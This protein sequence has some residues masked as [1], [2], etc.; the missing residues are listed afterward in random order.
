MTKFIFAC[1]IL[2]ACITA[3]SANPVDT[4]ETVTTGASL[5]REP[6]A[7]VAAWAASETNAMDLIR[8][9]AA[10]KKSHRSAAT[11]TL[12]GG[13]AAMIG[14]VAVSVAVGPCDQNQNGV[15]CSNPVGFVM[16]LGG[17]AATTTGGVMLF[18]E[19]SELKTLRTTYF[20][21]IMN[22]RMK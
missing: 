7:D 18:N 3:P 14:G 15:Q 10:A 5:L 11:L 1:C 8:N 22:K 2:A 4:A 19:P 13:V 21:Y 12:L 9:A 16:L 6:Y 20:R 17:M